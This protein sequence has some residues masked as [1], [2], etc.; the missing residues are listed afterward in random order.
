MKRVITFLFSLTYLITTGQTITVSEEMSLRNDVY[1]EIIGKLK[2]QLLLYRE[3][4]NDKFEV[5]AFDERLQESWNKELE[6]DK[7]RSQVIDII[8]ARNNF[9]LI[10]NFRKK[11]HTV[12]KVHKY[13]PGANLM[14]SVT[15]KDFGYLFYTPTFRV[16]ESEDKNKILVFYFEQQSTFHVLSFDLISMKKLWETS[17][18][19][20]DFILNRDFQQIEVSNEGSM[21]LVFQKDN[22]RHKKDE[23][24]FE[25]YE[26]TATT[27]ALRQ[28]KIPLQNYLTYDV[29]FS[30]DNLNNRLKAAGLYS[31]KNKARAVGYFYLNIPLENTQDHLLKFHEF[32]EEFVASLMEKDNRSSKGIID[33]TVH[34]LIVR[35]DGGVLMIGERIREYERRMAGS[36]RGYYDRYG[37]RYTVDYYHDDLFSISIHPNGETHWKNILRKKQYS[38]DDGAMY[39]SFFLLKTPSSLRL[40][41]NDEIKYENTVSEYVLK[42]NGEYDR[43]SVM[44][45]EN[46]QL[47]LRFRDAMQTASDELIVPSERRNRLK[48]VRV[49]Y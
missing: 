2:G 15:I 22:V 44:S 9:N 26:F 23:H 14:D 4:T 46:Q 47:R 13:D 1:Y 20:E 28:F 16:I 49:K 43:N 30:F 37:N 29:Y 21:Y 7:R 39:S 19:P 42:G 5:Q 33:A 32:D 36:G 41:F 24:R 48:L 3:E 34:E 35:R 8:P 45:T 11:S 31:D 12:L 40:L 18:K 17:F 27:N 6:L 10:Y 38:Q 25:I